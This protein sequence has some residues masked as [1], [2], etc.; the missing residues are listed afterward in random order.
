[1]NLN[2]V[3]A[4]IQLA[5]VIVVHLIREA[6]RK[7]NEWRDRKASGAPAPRSGT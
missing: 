2:R 4:V 7:Y 3:P 6:L 5:V 1:M